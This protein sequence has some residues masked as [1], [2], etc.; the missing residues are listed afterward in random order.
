MIY[1]CFTF[2]N[3]L[4]LLEIRLNELGGVVDRFVLV[5]S[6]KTFT[7]IDKPLH[8]AENKARFAHFHD[9][10]IHVVVDPIPGEGKHWEREE[11]QRNHILK[12]LETA[13]HDDTVIIGDVDE[14]PKADVVRAYQGTNQVL[15]FQLHH[16][17]Y[18]LNLFFGLWQNGTRMLR[19]GR[20]ET[21]QQARFMHDDMIRHAGWHFG[22]V[23][24]VDNI[25]RKLKSFS[26]VE[27]NVPPYNDP[28]HLARQVAKGCGLGD[29]TAGSLLHPDSLPM[30]VRN[31][32]DKFDKYMF[33]GDLPI[34]S[35]SEM[36]HIT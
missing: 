33:K 10:I 13:R 25:V 36:T 9:K 17:F 16:T 24:D 22:Y 27:V 18:Y 30:Y 32:P 2:F 28:Q 8:Y 6:P 34:I 21:P 4:D 26:H 35:E 15:V 29:D 23:G 11:Q 5:E 3:E 20:F 12:G 19:R 7:G 1:D 14:I 31:N